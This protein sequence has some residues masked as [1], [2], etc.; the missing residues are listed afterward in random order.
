M[1]PC[2]PGRLLLLFLA[3][4]GWG[5]GTATLNALFGDQIA[6]TSPSMK[7]DRTRTNPCGSCYG[8]KANTFVSAT[9]GFAQKPAHASASKR[10]FWNPVSRR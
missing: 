1:V 6:T 2:G 9:G 8:L 5:R 7:Q 4:R 3:G 10:R